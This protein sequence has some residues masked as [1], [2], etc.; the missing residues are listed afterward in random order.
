MNRF[1]KIGIA[2]AIGGASAVAAR[3]DGAAFDYTTYVSTMT[4]GATAVGTA[5]GLFAA[6]A[7]GVLVWRKIMKYSNK[8]G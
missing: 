5:A 2:L 6:I 3:A 8:G 7:A 4:T 1:K